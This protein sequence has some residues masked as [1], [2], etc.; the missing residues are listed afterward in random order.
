MISCTKEEDTTVEPKLI[1]RFRFDSTQERLNNTGQPSVL[2]EG[3]AAQSPLMNSMSAHYIEL[4][5]NSGT[6]LGGGTIIYRAE[7]TTS[8]G[9]SAINFDKSVL[10]GNN[11]VF[12]A[13]SLKDVAPG[14]YE[15]LRLSLAYQNY[16]IQYHIDTTIGDT[17]HI[18]QDFTGTLASFIGYNT[19]ISSYQIN[20]QTIELNE[21]KKQGYWGF[22][23]TINYEE[24]SKVDTV[25]GQAA[26]GATTVVNPLF[27]TSPVPVGSCVVTG[28]FA[29]NRLII[30]GNETKNIIVE[31]AVSTNKSFEWN[32]IIKNGR[33][34][35][36][37]GEAVVDMGVRGIIPKVL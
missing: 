29:G 13:I 19:Y 21:N 9:D 6:V 1:F 35:P 12:Y 36:T 22:E 4:A 16:T 8:G 23:S 26:P 34:E 10:A 37:K 33:W 32:D 17:L 14:E 2:P 25:F 15:W 30:T 18:D 31:V 11:E 28:A 20:T 5:P 27:A 7:E 24:F 3:H